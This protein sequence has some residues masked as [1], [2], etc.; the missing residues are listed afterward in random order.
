M[1][2]ATAKRTDD[3]QLGHYKC[4]RITAE[5]C[6]NENDMHRLKNLAK[7]LLPVMV[8]GERKVKKFAKV[9]LRHPT[10]PTKD[11]MYFAD[12]VTGTLYRESTG[13]SASPSLYIIQE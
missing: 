7:H 8:C 1:E 13:R 4:V 3:P 9:C 12:T 2:C 6:V 10:D 5:G 11:R